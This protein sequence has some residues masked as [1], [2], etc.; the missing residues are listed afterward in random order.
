MTE[1][2]RSFALFTLG[3]AKK[4]LVDTGQFSPIGFVRKDNA[5]LVVPMQFSNDEQKYRSYRTLGA[6]CRLSKVSLVVTV[7][8]AYLRKVPSNIP[9]DD[10][11]Y[12]NP[13][14]YPESM[15]QEC[16][17]VMVMDLER[18]RAY[19]CVMEYDRG[20]GVE[21]KDPTEFMDGDGALFS[22]VIEGWQAVSKL[23]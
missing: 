9:E 23:T 4:R 10:L 5:V 7:N 6:F 8:D 14:Y 3:F 11:K 16:L 13:V 12:E 22:S 20:D 1:E 18:R 19:T 15:K 21:F 17:V 2:M